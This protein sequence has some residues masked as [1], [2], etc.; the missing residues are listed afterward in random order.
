MRVTAVEIHTTTLEE[1]IEIPLDSSDPKARY[2]IKSI[3]GLD[4]DAIFAKFDGWNL[5]DGSGFYSLNM[6]SRE[7]VMQVGLRPRFEMDET[8]SDIRDE[9][10]RA[11]S[12]TRT[13]LIELR[14]KAGAFYISSIVGS[15]NK[16]EADLF[17]NSPEVRITFA[18]DDPMFRGINPVVYEPA[19]LGANRLVVVPDS[20][21]TAPHG[22]EM[23]VTFH[24]T[25][26]QFNIQ[27]DP[28]DPTWVFQVIPSGG[29]AIGDVLN[30][31][32]EVS[33]KQINYVRSG[34]TTQLADKISP[35]SVWPII[36]PGMNAFHFMEYNKFN[37]NYLQFNPCYWGV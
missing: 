4:A 27:D 7:I 28:V 9:L 11:I 36:F 2:A 13:G 14:F 20:L 32:S 16:V 29:F 24:A 8:Y 30:I 15:I 1:P 10:Y 37:W 17:T 18:C 35:S 21:S 6:H 19:S 5:N 34:V 22:F 12:A 25:S 3:I 26:A 31:S 23:Q 33:N